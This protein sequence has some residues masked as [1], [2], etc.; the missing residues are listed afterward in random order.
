MENLSEEITFEVHGLV[1]LEI[2]MCYDR[3]EQLYCIGTFVVLDFVKSTNCWYFTK[4]ICNN[5]KSEKICACFHKI[6]RAKLLSFNTFKRY[7]LFHN[8]NLNILN[9]PPP[10][11]KCITQCKFF[12]PHFKP[13]DKSR[14]YAGF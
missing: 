6:M 2:L 11:S 7:Y 10:L 9:A 14:F 4:K 5:R 3:F 12:K 8:S 1:R 13:N